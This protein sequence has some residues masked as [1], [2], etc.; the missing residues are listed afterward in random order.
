MPQTLF[1]IHI[2]SKQTSKG[3]NIRNKNRKI[4]DGLRTVKP[5]VGVKLITGHHGLGR[6]KSY[7]LHNSQGPRVDVGHE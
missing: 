1:L 4:G 3:R 6:I 7:E 5:V 2:C